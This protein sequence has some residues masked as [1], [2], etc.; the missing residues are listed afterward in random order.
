[1]HEV[2][3]VSHQQQLD[4]QMV[5]AF[6]STDP[7]LTRLP[8]CIFFNQDHPVRIIAEVVKVPVGVWGDIWFV[9]AEG[10][11]YLPPNDGHIIEDFKL[12]A[13]P[14]NQDYA[15]QFEGS[16]GF[17]MVIPANTSP[18]VLRKTYDLA[19]ENDGEYHYDT[20]IEGI[21]GLI[22]EIGWAYIPLEIQNDYAMF[23][24]SQENA[25][26]VQEVKRRLAQAGNPVIFDVSQS[27]T[28]QRWNGPI[29]WNTW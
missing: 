10:E 23:V 1:M 4:A 6:G 22:P 11:Y 29:L 5:A 16:Y 17:T 28:G 26:I 13:L 24:T 14:A 7:P 3:S 18:N 15:H 9:D 25:H 21:A 27:E 19:G 20:F 2:M 12:W 8:H